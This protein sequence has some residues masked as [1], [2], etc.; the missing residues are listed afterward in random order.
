MQ[1]RVWALYFPTDDTTGTSG[2]FGDDDGADDADDGAEPLAHARSKT[3]AELAQFLNA[4]NIVRSAV[5]DPADVIA[6][7][8]TLHLSWAALSRA[9]P[10][11]AAAPPV[12]SP[13]AHGSATLRPQLVLDCLA[14]LAH[15]DLLLQVS[16]LRQTNV[17]TSLSRWREIERGGG[18]S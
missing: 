2:L 14:Y 15:E 12:K 4:S 1:S 13:F 10:T 17:A 6:A 11:A 8:H 3:L 16:L 7:Q 18:G 5:A 9:A